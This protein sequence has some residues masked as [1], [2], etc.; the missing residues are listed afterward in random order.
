[1]NAFLNTLAEKNKKIYEFSLLSR[2]SPDKSERESA[3]KISKEEEKEINDLL[4]PDLYKSV[5]WEYLSCKKLV[6]ELRLNGAHLLPA[7]SVEVHRINN[8]LIDLSA[9]FLK[10]I[11]DNSAPKLQ[12]EP[13][14]REHVKELLT[15]SSEYIELTPSNH[16]KLMC[17]C[18]DK[19]IRRRAF[20]LKNSLPPENI[21]VLSEAYGLRRRKAQL[22]GYTT[23]AEMYLS[24]SHMKSYDEIMNFLLIL[25]AKLSDKSENLLKKVLKELGEYPSLDLAE[26][27]S[28]V[29]SS[30]FMAKY[31]Q[32][33][34]LFD[35][36]GEYF[37]FDRVLD[38][39][40]GF[41]SDKLNIKIDVFYEDKWIK[42]MPVL[43]V[44]NTEKNRLL[45]KISLD[46]FFREGKHPH[47]TCWLMKRRFANP[48]EM[49]PSAETCL[50]VSLQQNPD[51][52]P[53]LM[54]HSELITIFHELGH[55]LHEILNETNT[56]NCGGIEMERDL[57]EVISMYFENYCWEKEL[58]KK[59]CDLSS[60]ELDSLI[61]TRNI[62]LPVSWL[63]QCA[64]SILDQ[65]LNSGVT[66]VDDF[67][68][69]YSEITGS[70][71]IDGTNM[72]MRWIHQFGYECQYYS[73]VYSNCY[74][75][76]LWADRN[77]PDHNDRLRQFMQYSS[78]ETLEKHFGK[79]DL[80]HFVDLL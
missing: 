70:E 8:K 64:F 67:E 13:E 61:S 36:S 66:R 55:G 26:L 9:E 71:Y 79:L 16:S 1:M 80:K 57:V 15:D 60:D 42:K 33:V 76:Q 20:T 3:E 29:S 73:Y 21:G 72:A 62:D 56:V 52:K 10:N 19:T 17:I 23:T 41:Y 75:A 51:G 46:M 78:G 14:N 25:S 48:D 43:F 68:K 38:T 12:I 6:N 54:S 69:R 24:D 50:T 58:L 27:K 31:K 74:A 45:G 77:S 37:D 4:T 65:E 49:F 28:P 44:R 59:C 11:S 5:I 2:V 22:L 7:D 18:P 35:Y 32:K 34:C 63:S 30:Y 53:R 40:S 39:I 47:G